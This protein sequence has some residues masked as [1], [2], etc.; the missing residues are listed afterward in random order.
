MNDD[1]DINV[2]A[3][4]EEWLTKTATLIAIERAAAGGLVAEQLTRLHASMTA[5]SDVMMAASAHC[6]A[7][8]CHAEA[9]GFNLHAVWVL[10]DVLEYAYCVSERAEMLRE[11]MGDPAYDPC[12][13]IDGVVRRRLSVLEWVGCAREVLKIELP[14]WAVLDY[15]EP[16]VAWRYDLEAKR[17]MRNAT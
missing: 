7:L 3:Q 15:D 9:I 8:V 17:W 1:P 12:D 2:M 16:P 4:A 11:N 5:S 13:E 6:K 10:A 14:A